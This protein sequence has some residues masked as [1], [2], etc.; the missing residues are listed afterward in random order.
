MLKPMQKDKS[1]RS[2]EFKKKKKRHIP[3][4]QGYELPVTSHQ[5]QYKP[6]DN[7]T[8]SGKCWKEKLSPMNYISSKNI[9]EK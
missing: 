9:L 8:T 7:A 6:E 3:G 5:K 2:Q 4:E 1:K